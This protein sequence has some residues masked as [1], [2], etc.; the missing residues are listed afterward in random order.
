MFTETDMLKTDTLLLE[1][2]QCMRSI[3]FC[4]LFRLWIHSGLNLV[5][6][7]DKR[8]TQSLIY[9]APQ[10]FSLNTPSPRA[11]NVD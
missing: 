9:E 7:K 4:D 6:H 10:G 5:L 1:A 8:F 2:G 11:T 3:M